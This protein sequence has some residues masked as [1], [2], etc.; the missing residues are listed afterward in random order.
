MQRPTLVSAAIAL[1]G[2]CASGLS[3]AGEV[4][5]PLGIPGWGVGYAHPINDQFAVRG[6]YMTL[7]T[8]SGSQTEDGIEYDGKLKLNRAAVF[9]DWF[10]WSGRFRLT[11]GLA[12]TN[13]KLEM[14]ASGAGRTI[15]VGDTNYTLTSA[16]GLNVEVKFPSTMPYLGLGWG[17]QTGSGFRFSFD[18]GAL[19]GKAKVSATGRGQ[20][21]NDAAQAD[22]D[23]ELQE[24]RD[25]VGKA[26]FIP[27]V[28]I[29]LGYSF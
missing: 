21:A 13:Y 17:H 7:G 15:T 25:G 28:S 29:G 18:L 24:L 19:I 22:I 5:V 3:Q 26:S 9:A 10:P 20:L 12:A 16:D 2:L 1:I 14:D 27:Q 11:A 6:D 8:R 4:Y 23:K